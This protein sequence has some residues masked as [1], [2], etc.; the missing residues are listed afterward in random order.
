MKRNAIHLNYLS[1]L[2]WI[3]LLD[4]RFGLEHLI[5]ELG[6]LSD[7]WFAFH[8]RQW[9]RSLFSNAPRIP[10]NNLNSFHIQALVKLK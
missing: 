3:V 5:A 4:Y 8:G 7:C 10:K 6:M 2:P 1:R 9:K